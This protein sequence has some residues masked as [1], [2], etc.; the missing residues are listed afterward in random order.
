MMML[1]KKY[2]PYIQGNLVLKMIFQQNLLFLQ[3]NFYLR[4]FVSMGK[5]SVHSRHWFL[6]SKDENKSLDRKGYGG[7]L[8][9]DLSK[10]FDNLNHDLLLPKLHAY[11]FDRESLKVLYSYLGQRCQRKKID[12]SFSWSNCLYNVFRKSVNCFWS[13]LLVFMYNLLKKL[14]FIYNLLYTTFFVLYKDG[15]LETSKM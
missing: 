14:S 7:V 6:C 2:V 3:K 15:L 10:T 5:A 8:L 9:M 1:I 11:G 4:T 12:S 13:T